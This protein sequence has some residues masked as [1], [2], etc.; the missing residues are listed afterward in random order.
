MLNKNTVFLGGAWNQ[1]LPISSAA[2]VGAAKFESCEARNC[3]ARK[4][5]GKFI[6][7]L[8]NVFQPIPI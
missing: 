4:L 5:W 7:N 2:L 3:C 8:L 1:K 6:F